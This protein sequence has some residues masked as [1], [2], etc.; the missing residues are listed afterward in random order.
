M[1]PELF[2]ATCAF[3]YATCAFHDHLGPFR[4]PP[5]LQPMLS[6]CELAADEQA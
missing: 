6:S 5:V 2:M 4:M 1:P 3:S